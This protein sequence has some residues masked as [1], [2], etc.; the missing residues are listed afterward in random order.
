MNTI[1]IIEDDFK[2]REEIKVFLN[3][4]GY[5]T[6]LIDN[7]QNSIEEVLKVLPDLLLLDLNLP[8][9][10]GH[11][12]CKELRKQSDIPIVVITSQNSDLDEL[13]SINFG[14]DDFISKPFNPQILL[15]RIQNIFR[16]TQVI[17]D[18]I[19]YKDVSLNL[20]NSTLTYKG[21]V[22]DLTK[23]EMK[24][25]HVLMSEPGI[26]ISRDDLIE[27]LWQSNDFIDDNTL[28][29]NINRLRKKLTGAG[30]EDF[31]ITKRG[32]GYIV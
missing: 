22:V 1:A 8:Y 30:L 9:V 27:A 10:D 24:I 25:L 13:M 12:I 31:L 7:F 23:N 28:T 26:I 20:S 15:A 17:Q 3:R 4:N 5:E 32:Q 19:I 6:L 18:K 14:A 16:R 2:I 11:F 29:V 21:E